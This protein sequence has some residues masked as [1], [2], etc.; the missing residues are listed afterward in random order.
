M[1]S[2]SCRFQEKYLNTHT[3][4]EPFTTSSHNRMR[5]WQ[6][7]SKISVDGEVVCDTF[8]EEQEEEADDYLLSKKS[9]PTWEDGR[10][11]NSNRPS[12]APCNDPIY[13]EGERKSIN[14]ETFLPSSGESVARRAKYLES[15][16]CLCVC[17]RACV[18]TLCPSKTFLPLP[19]S[20]RCPRSRDLGRSIPKGI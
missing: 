11:V 16:A 15:I 1:M 9:G 4:V 7:D 10:F 18:S 3:Q 17:V 8:R 5:Q 20:W 2:W 19:F 6:I 13:C 14:G 12:R